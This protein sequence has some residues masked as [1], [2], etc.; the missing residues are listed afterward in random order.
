MSDQQ[1]RAAERQFAASPTKENQAALLICRQ[2]AG[3]LSTESLQLAA[4]CGYEAARI[5]LGIDEYHAS[6][7]QSVQEGKYLTHK[8][9][10]YCRFIG[11][12]RWIDLLSEHFGLDVMTRAIFA[13]APLAVRAYAVMRA[14]TDTIMYSPD[15]DAQAAAFERQVELRARPVME[16]MSVMQRSFERKSRDTY[17]SPVIAPSWY[18]ELVSSEPN[19]SKVLKTMVSDSHDC[20]E[21]IRTALAHWALDQG[22]LPRSEPWV[23]PE[24][25]M[26]ALEGLD[27][28]PWD[29][30][31]DR[32]AG[33]T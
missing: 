31:D 26:Q 28:L 15:P 14:G 22:I 23:L 17:I 32:L 3:Q 12:N 30:E 5:A 19:L 20:L 21:T 29:E 27:P 1:L 33:A 6:D 4:F 2:R 11:P 10:D 16:A 13:G 8:S 9:G 25:L 18:W 24:G 7:C